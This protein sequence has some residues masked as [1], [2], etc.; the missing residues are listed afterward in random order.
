LARAA[1]N[2][3]PCHSQGKRKNGFDFSENF[4][5]TTLLAVMASAKLKAWDTCLLQGTLS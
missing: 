4:S 5:H 2:A 1:L 3:T